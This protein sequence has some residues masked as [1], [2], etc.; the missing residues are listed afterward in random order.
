FRALGL[1]CAGCPA[2]LG[3]VGPE[4]LVT[5]AGDQFP[6]MGFA[7]VM[8]SALTGLAVVRM[9]FSLFCG[10]PAPPTHAA[11]LLA[12]KRREAWTFGGVVVTLIVLGIAPRLLVNSR[13]AA[14][15]DLLRLRRANPA[16]SGRRISMPSSALIHH[17]NETT[18]GDGD[19]KHQSR[20]TGQ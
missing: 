10:R 7:I 20:S 19:L 15:D 5:G 14:A 1:A 6:V 2:P 18:T 3:C 16:V 4:L 17:P 13:F 8:A 11:A 12:L 9:Y